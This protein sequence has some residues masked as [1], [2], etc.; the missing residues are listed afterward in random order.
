MTQTSFSFSQGKHNERCGFFTLSVPAFPTD[1]TTSRFPKG[2]TSKQI[3]WRNSLGHVKADD[4]FT[5]SLEIWR[6]RNKA[7]RFDDNV[8][9]VT[10]PFPS[11]AGLPTTVSCSTLR[12]V[13]YMRYLHEHFEVMLSNTNSWCRWRH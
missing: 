5:F 11:T 2:Q 4:R 8:Q 3:N 12:Q 10:S 6:N 13:Y 1:V 9:T 7:D